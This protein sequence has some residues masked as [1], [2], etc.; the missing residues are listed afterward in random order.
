MAPTSKERS[1]LIVAS[2][3]SARTLRALALLLLRDQP[4][5][6]CRQRPGGVTSISGARAETVAFRRSLMRAFTALWSPQS[7]SFGTGS[8]DGGDRKSTR[9]NSSHVRISYA[10]FCLKKKKK[11]KINLI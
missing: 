5:T 2:H 11:K 3:Q 6:Y 4:K 8:R 10:V 7:N 1:R 9:L